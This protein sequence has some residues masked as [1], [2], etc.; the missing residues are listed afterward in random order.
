MA[1]SKQEG[2]TGYST[3]ANYPA[4]WKPE[5]DMYGELCSLAESS[6]QSHFSDKARQGQPPVFKD[7]LLTK[8]GKDSEA[9]PRK[10]IPH[11][12]LSLES[13]LVVGNC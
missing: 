1:T 8:T 3:A 12:A 7:T 9:P 13:N 2:L 4:G 6:Q 11:F 10:G 5:R